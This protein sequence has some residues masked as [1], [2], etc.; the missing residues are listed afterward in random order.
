MYSST[1]RENT[2]HYYMIHV[3]NELLNP[4]FLS[5]LS[6]WGGGGTELNQYDM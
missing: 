6:K 1:Q 4:A 3:R 5:Y 2:T